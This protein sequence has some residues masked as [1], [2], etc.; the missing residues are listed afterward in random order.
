MTSVPERLR[1][2]A[3]QISD[4]CLPSRLICDAP[5]QIACELC[6][7]VIKSAIRLIFHATSVLSPIF[8]FRF[9]FLKKKIPKTV[10]AALITAE[11]S[12]SKYG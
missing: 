6:S 1:E 10:I 4:L 3:T 2:E 12:I 5:A 7:L 8:Y 9:F 11:Y